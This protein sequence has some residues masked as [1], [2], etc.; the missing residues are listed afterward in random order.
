MADQISISNMALTR[1]G[2]QRIVSIDQTGIEANLCKLYLDSTLEELLSMN[3]WEFALKR[4][5][6]TI[7]GSANLTK[8]TY[9]YML[10]T[11][12]INVTTMLDEDYNDADYEWIKEGGYLYSDYTPGLIKY[13]ALITDYNLLPQPFTEA[14]YLRLATK[15]GIKLTQDQ[16]LMAMLYQEYAAAIKGAM[17]MSN[18]NRQNAEP[19]TVLW[20]E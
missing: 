10:S 18:A 17:G 1:L 12:T 4:A 19:A 6:L 8:Y 11:D 16:S 2:M 20:S 7:D 15:I 3:N 14:L 13:V 5:T 9:K